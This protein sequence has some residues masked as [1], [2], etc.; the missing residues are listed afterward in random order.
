ML[1]NVTLYSFF[2][3]L[4]VIIFSFS[5]SGKKKNNEQ[6]HLLINGIETLEI[7]AQ[8][9]IRRLPQQHLTI[10]LLGFGNLCFLCHNNDLVEAQ[11]SKY[12][13]IDA[14]P[15]HFDSLIH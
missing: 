8:V 15:N 1:C 12:K 9:S 11:Q 6:T 10:K 5:S 3:V 4:L 13:Q 14:W 2:A 7:G